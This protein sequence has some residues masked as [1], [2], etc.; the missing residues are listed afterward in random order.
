M[1][2]GKKHRAE[3]A[4]SLPE[5]R[6]LFMSYKALKREVKLINPI[7]FNSNGKK[8]SRSWPTEDMGFAL[9]LARELDKINTFYIDK[10]EDYIIGFKELEI[11]AENVNGNEEMLELQKEILGFHSEMVML[12]H[13]SVINF[14]GLMK[15]VKKHKKRTGAYTSVYS[16]YMPRVL[17]QPFFSTD[18]LYN[19]IKG[20]E[21][22]LDRLSPPNHP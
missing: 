2:H 10:E 19:L 15:I 20:C 21:E 12:L 14:A 1:K 8:R 6:D 4:K 13:Y 5:W 9:L 7:R 18:L 11:R 22:I 17:Q 16:F 3:V